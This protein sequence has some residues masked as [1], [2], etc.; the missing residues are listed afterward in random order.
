MFKK[1]LEKYHICQLLSSASYNEYIQQNTTS[2]VANIHAALVFSKGINVLKY[3]EYVVVFLLS[4]RS[5]AFAKYANSCVYSYTQMCLCMNIST[6]INVCDHVYFGL[7]RK[8][9]FLTQNV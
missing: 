1:N 9:N 6:L 5:A 3:L 4:I 8:R 7:Q 2:N